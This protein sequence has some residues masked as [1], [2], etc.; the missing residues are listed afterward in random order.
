MFHC[1]LSLKYRSSRNAEMVSPVPPISAYPVTWMQYRSFIEA[2]DGYQNESW[3]DGLAERQHVPGGQYRKLDNHPAENVSWY[4]AVAFCRWLTEQMGYEKIIRLPTEWEWHYA[5]TGGYPDNKYPWGA[6]WDSAR[7]N[8]DESELY[9]TTA[10]G[11]YPQGLSPVKAF[12]MS[13]NIWEWCLNEHDKPKRIKK[14]GKAS[15]AVRG[16]SDNHGQYIARC[17]M[18]NHYDPAY[19]NRNLGFRLLCSSPTLS[20]FFEFMRNSHYFSEKSIVWHDST[21][22]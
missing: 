21:V 15:R 12:D 20:P 19:R 14:T 10:V 11:M 18:R 22:C 4:E 7:T 6:K 17:G 2:K 16:G 8:T 13:G 3:W 9:R 1:T 5:A